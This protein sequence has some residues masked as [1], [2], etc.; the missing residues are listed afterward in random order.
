MKVFLGVAILI[1]SS[2][3]MAA[4]PQKNAPANGRTRQIFV[5]VVDRT[6]A[7][8]LDLGPGDFD[9]SEK[10]VKRSV[11]RAGLATSPMRV[12]LL[13]DTSDAAG[14]ALTDIRAGLLAFLDALP[15]EEEVL[16]VT[17]GRQLRVRV[18]PT[19]DRTK[20]KKEAG[21]LFPDGAGTVLMDGLLEIDD[22][23]MRKAEDR[24]P[25][26]VMITSDG[27][28]SSAGAH[29]KEFNQWTVG[30]T[31][32]GVSAHALVLKVAKAGGIPEIVAMNVTQNA[33]GHYDVINTSTSIP[34]KL[35]TLA[36]QLAAD[37]K[38]MGGKY[39]IDYATDVATP[40][41]G[42]DIGVARQGVTV[43]MSYQ[44]R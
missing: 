33:G 44:R 26:F 18:Q 29:E 6:G 43:Q 7:P 35:K 28:E 15:P 36:A 23:F 1:A 21:G 13:V 30:L 2:G 27:T 41:P 10:G 11:V 22:R 32:R 8:V 5:S 34:D 24:W 3:L 40:Q 31:T 9:V 38:R 16:L 4:A 17:T 19:A 20:L 25:V 42:L 14:A 37:R 39:Q 12:A